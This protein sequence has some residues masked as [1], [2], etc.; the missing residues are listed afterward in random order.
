[1]RI[2]KNIGHMV[3]LETAKRTAL[4]IT[5]SDEEEQAF[6]PKEEGSLQKVKERTL[7]RQT[8]LLLSHKKKLS[9]LLPRLRRR[10]LL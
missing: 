7:R 5:G 2:R 4:T 1:M 10:L 3:S 9:L 8:Q 6:N